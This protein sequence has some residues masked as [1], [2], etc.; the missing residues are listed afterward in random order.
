[1]PTLSRTLA[2]SLWLTACAATTTSVPPTQ[3]TAGPRCEG[4]IVAPDSLV[5][6]V[7]E[8]LLASSLGQINEG[9]LCQGRTYRALTP[10]RVYRLWNRA[11]SYTQLGRWWTFE[12]PHG[13]VEAL[14]AS[15]EVCPEWS[16]LDV[17]SEC[18]LTAGSHVVVGTGQSAQCQSNVHYNI[19][20]VPQVYIPNDTRAT[21]AQVYVTDCRELSPWPE[22]P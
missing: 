21:P 8:P 4:T 1:M 22:T 16:P 13:P 20:A 5:P 3:H 7:D 14:R 18:T 10:V 17:L 2:L 15:L 11:Q 9:K 6:V 19:S 12:R